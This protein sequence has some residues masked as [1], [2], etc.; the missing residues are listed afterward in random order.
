MRKK[1]ERAIESERDKEMETDE[2]SW[3]KRE[4]EFHESLKYV[5]MLGSQ[6]FCPDGREVTLCQARR[7]QETSPAL[8]GGCGGRREF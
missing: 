6:S 4:N 7:G 2:E 1:K 5:E 3:E 8:L